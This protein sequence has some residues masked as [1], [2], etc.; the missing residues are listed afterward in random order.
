MKLNTTI[1]ALPALAAVSLHGIAWAAEGEV[2]AGGSV[3]GSAS[4]GTGS[5]ETTTTT[6][7][8]SADGNTA[9]QTTAETTVAAPAT[10]G[11]PVPVAATGSTDHAGVVGSFGI[12]YFL[13]TGVQIPDPLNNTV[14]TANAPV[15]G[16]RYWITPRWGIDA[17]LGF[18]IGGASDDQG[19]G[20]S[21]DSPQPIAFALHGGL[22]LALMDSQHFVFQVVPEFTL[23]VASNTVTTPVAGDVSLGGFH[24]DIGARAGA[25]IHF[26]F[27]D[28]PRLALQ[29]GIGLYLQMNSY[30]ADPDNG[31]KVSH[32]DYSF[33]TASGPAPWSLFTSSLAVL[34]Y[35]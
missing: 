19:N 24:F 33:G 14:I 12:G 21:V 29:A 6:T 32:S 26:G 31:G 28:L 25:E 15:I 10:S 3:G 20:T 30:S 35:F 5:A 2:G 13:T 4:G 17:G 34:Y 18:G 22:P 16:M 23:G 27:I 7:T 1:L 8:V 9:T 11:E